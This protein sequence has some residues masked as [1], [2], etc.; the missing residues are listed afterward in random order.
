MGG[1][2]LEKNQAVCLSFLKLADDSL[3]QLSPYPL[4]SLH[5]GQSIRQACRPQMRVPRQH[6]QRLASGNGCDFHDI[7]VRKLEKGWSPR[8]GGHRNAGFQAL[9]SWTRMDENG[10]G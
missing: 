10:G 8:A 4:P 5:P 9:P 7:Q 2:P 3:Q 1:R 6:L